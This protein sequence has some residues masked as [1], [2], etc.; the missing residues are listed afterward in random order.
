MSVKSKW[1]ELY[2][3]WLKI[4]KRESVTQQN[5]SSKTN[6]SRIERL[7]YLLN[8][9]AVLKLWNPLTKGRIRKRIQNQNE[10]IVLC[11]IYVLSR[12]QDSHLSSYAKV[13]DLL[14]TLVFLGFSYRQTKILTAIRVRYDWDQSK[15]F[16][17]QTKSQVVVRHLNVTCT[18]P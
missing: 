7:S 16:T 6:P 11:C 12:I 13:F 10:K 14:T 17:K 5:F 2:M 1:R 4:W 3:N 9:F 18:R 15:P 8:S